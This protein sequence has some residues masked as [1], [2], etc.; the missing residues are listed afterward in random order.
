M[1]PGLGA[2]I[3]QAPCDLQ[4]TTGRL[5]AEKLPSGAIA[6]RPIAQCSHAAPCEASSCGDCS[7]GNQYNNSQTSTQMPGRNEKNIIKPQYLSKEEAS[8]QGRMKRRAG[9]LRKTARNIIVF[10]VALEVVAVAYAIIATRSP[11]LSW[12]MRAGHVLPMFVLPALSSAIYSI[13]MIFDPAAKA[14]AATVL[15]SKIGA[16][17]GL[18][19]YLGDKSSNVELVQS[20]GLRS[21]KQPR[22]SHQSM[23]HEMLLQFVRETSRDVSADDQEVSAQTQRDFEHYKSSGTSGGWWIAAMLVGALICRNCHMHNGLARKE[24]FPYITYFCPHCHALNVSRQAADSGFNSGEIASSEPSNDRIISPDVSKGSSITVVEVPCK[25]ATSEE[26]I[27]DSK[28]E[29]PGVP[30]S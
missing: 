1:L 12:Q 19:V 6:R 4:S 30:I 14:A 26:P 25:L 23:G 2:V 28:I 24:D 29:Q 16:D 22:T 17:S 8:V 5:A 27:E 20:G 7:T 11:E 10:S 3:V 21:R 18:K 13:G 9:R 15:A